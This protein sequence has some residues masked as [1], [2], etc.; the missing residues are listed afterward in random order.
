MDL[1]IVIPAYNEAERI[2]RTLHAYATVF[3]DAELIVVLNGC[4]D[5]TQAVVEAFQKRGV[6]QV[7]LRDIPEAVGKGRAV[8]EGFR[9]SRGRLVGFVDADAATSP[10]EFRRLV[11]SIDGAAAAIA[12][13]WLPGAV[14]R[15]RTWLRTLASRTFQLAVRMLFGL[16]FRDTQCGAKVFRRDVID[17]ILPRLRIDNMAF[18]VELLYLTA[19]ASFRILEVPTVWEDQSR[20]AILGSPLKLARNAVRMLTSLV[21]LR[22]R[23]ARSRG[24]R[25]MRSPSTPPSDAHHSL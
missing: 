17:A 5:N 4:R 20:S 21:S 13:R 3:P 15:N 25:K 6:G 11:A 8:R 16:P 1:S 19:S 2:D 24:E 23:G 14:V 12:S 22:L 10:K 9:M 18:D 7:R